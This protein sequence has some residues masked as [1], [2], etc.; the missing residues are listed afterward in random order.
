[1]GE[2][3]IPQVSTLGS[4]LCNG[5]FGCRPSPFRTAWLGRLANCNEDPIG[6]QVLVL[7]FTVH[8]LPFQYGWI[9]AEHL[10]FGNHS[11]NTPPECSVVLIQLAILFGTCIIHDM[12]N[13]NTTTEEQD[14]DTY[15]LALADRLETDNADIGSEFD[16]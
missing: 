12:M 14:L 2:T 7:D 3:S 13:E 16:N 10:G 5:S 8:C 11:N 9:M 4:Q 15:W 1:M 6:G